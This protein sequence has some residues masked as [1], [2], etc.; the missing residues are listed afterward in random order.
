MSRLFLLFTIVPF[1]ELYLLLRLGDAI[2]FWPTVGMVLV[3]ALIGASL[4]RR[5]GLKALSEWQTTLA[6]GR[7]PAEGLLGGVLILIGGALLVAPGV[8]TDLA[9]LALLFPPTRRI[10]ATQVRKRLEKNVQ[11]GR[12]RFTTYGGVPNPPRAAEPTDASW[13][14]VARSV[15][16]E[17]DAE[18]E[19]VVVEDRPKRV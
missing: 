16:R 1:V 3:T 18:E 19:A 15:G 8:L 14:K 6:Q 10:V 2:G 17:E 7:M 13:E 5:E 12:I 9:G 11:S 4:A